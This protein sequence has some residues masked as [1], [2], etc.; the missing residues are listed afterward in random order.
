M[1]RFAAKATTDQL[2]ALDV[3]VCE[4]KPARWCVRAWLRLPERSL[5]DETLILSFDIALSQPHADAADLQALTIN[6]PVVI[7]D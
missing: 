2:W 1:R 6:K 5:G 4:A 7:Y 3:D